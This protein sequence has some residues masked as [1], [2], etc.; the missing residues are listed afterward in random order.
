MTVGNSARLLEAAQTCFMSPFP[1]PAQRRAGRRAGGQAGNHMAVQVGPS[2]RQLHALATLPS[3]ARF[4]SVLFSPCLSCHAA[5]VP[6][7]SA[8]RW[9]CQA[10]PPLTKQ[11]KGPLRWPKKGERYPSE[12]DLRERVAWHTHY[13]RESSAS[14]RERRSS[15][16]SSPPLF[17][18]DRKPESSRY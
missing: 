6:S 4:G 13:C 7:R 14:Q 17:G 10:Q 11:S 1:S 3:P 12:A 9:S 16:L 2:Q 8:L 15:P 18:D 5:A